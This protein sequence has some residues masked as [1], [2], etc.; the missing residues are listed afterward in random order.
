MREALS[1]V[2]L[3]RLIKII[4]RI[5]RLRKVIHTLV[6]TVPSRLPVSI[7]L[8]SLNLVSEPWGAHLPLVRKQEDLG[9]GI[10]RL[11][12]VPG[13]EPGRANQRDEQPE[14]QRIEAQLHLEIT[15]DVRVPGVSLSV[16]GY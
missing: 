11:A 7:K 4:R 9:V 16:H 12:I 2:T 13:R 15:S 10:S 1:L 6:T 14:H 8:I 5:N 3:K